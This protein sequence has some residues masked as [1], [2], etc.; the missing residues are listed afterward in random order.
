MTSLSIPK[1][2]RE[3]VRRRVNFRCEY[4]PQFDRRQ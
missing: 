3:Q 2:L 1:A 4:Y